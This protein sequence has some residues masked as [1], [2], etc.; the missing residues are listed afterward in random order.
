MSDL[1]SMEGIATRWCLAVD[2]KHAVFAQGLPFTQF[3]AS[4]QR[5]RWSRLRFRLESIQCWEEEREASHR[6]PVGRTPATIASSAAAP[7]SSLLGDWRN[8][9]RDRQTAGPKRRPQCAE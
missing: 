1:L 6:P 3:G 7:T 9:A 5:I 2:V 8:G 4:T